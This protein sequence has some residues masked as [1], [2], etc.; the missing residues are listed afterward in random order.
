MKTR[1]LP[2][3]L[4]LGYRAI[5]GDFLGA[6]MYLFRCPANIGQIS[7]LPIFRGEKKIASQ[8]V[9]GLREHHCPIGGAQPTRDVHFNGGGT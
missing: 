7:P 4:L 8:Q 3:C 1:S 6:S 2:F 9:V 5:S